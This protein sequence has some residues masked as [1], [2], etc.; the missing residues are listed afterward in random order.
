MIQHNLKTILQSALTVSEVKFT[1]ASGNTSNT[2]LDLS[3]VLRT[4]AG[5]TALVSHLEDI[6]HEYYTCVGGPLN[7]SDLVAFAVTQAWN[8][9][10]WFGI[11]KAPKNRGYDI[12]RITGN[13]Q[14]GDRVLLVEDVCTTGGTIVQAAPHI[15]GI[16]AKISGILTVVD[17]GGLE[18][19]TKMLGV[20][21]KALFTLEELQG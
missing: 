10:K 15:S 14:A 3:K 18:H 6:G 13:L 16:G 21:G 8:I 11:R 2:M 12:G 4:K 1:M 20:P 9:D 7:G 5:Q 19:A 17:R